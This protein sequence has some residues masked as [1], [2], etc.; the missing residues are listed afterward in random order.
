MK[1]HGRSSERVD[2]IEKKKIEHFRTPLQ[3]NEGYLYFLT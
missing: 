3:S 1:G 2:F